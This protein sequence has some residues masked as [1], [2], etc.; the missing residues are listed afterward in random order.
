MP[1]STVRNPSSALAPNKNLT[2]ALSAVFAA[3]A[4]IAVAQE[5]DM[6]N[7]IMMLEE[8]MVTARKRSESAMQIPESIQAITEQTPYWIGRNDP[9]T[10]FFGHQNDLCGCHF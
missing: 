1:E 3:P 6:T 4:G 7:D 10:H 8:V 5:E 2:F 9:P